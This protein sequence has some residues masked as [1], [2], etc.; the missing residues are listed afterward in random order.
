VLCE[1]RDDHGGIF[2]PL[3]LA[4]CCGTGGNEDVKL[5]ETVNDRAFE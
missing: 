2:G 1:D 3:A 5:A 4:D